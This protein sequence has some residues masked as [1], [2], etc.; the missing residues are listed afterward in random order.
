M[1][2]MWILCLANCFFKKSVLLTS[3]SEYFNLCISLFFL[4][5]TPF[6]LILFPMLLAPDSPPL[7]PQFII[8]IPNNNISVVSK[9][10]EGCRVCY[11]SIL[12]C[13]MND[14]HFLPKLNSEKY[15]SVKYVMLLEKCSFL[16]ECAKLQFHLIWVLSLPWL[17]ISTAWEQCRTSC[18]EAKH[19]CTNSEQEEGTGS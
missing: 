6:L 2:S 17:Q 14:Q 11:W 12:L 15:D 4:C 16:E 19:H 5:V 1:L 3:I 13:N 10:D 18:S 8:K 9:R 7:P